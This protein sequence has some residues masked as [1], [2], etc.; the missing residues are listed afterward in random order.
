MWWTAAAFAGEGVLEPGAWFDQ[1]QVLEVGKKGK[2][3]N[4]AGG[5]PEKIKRLAPNLYGS[6]IGTGAV[7]LPLWRDGAGAVWT[8]SALR[9][10]DDIVD[11]YG[12]WWSWVDGSCVPRSE[13][14]EP[15]NCGM[16]G[17]RFLLNDAV[18]QPLAPGVWADAGRRLFRG[19]DAAAARAAAHDGFLDDATRKRFGATGTWW[20][21]D[22]ETSTLRE[23]R[24]DGAVLALDDTRWP[25]RPVAPCFLEVGEEG[26]RSLQAFW[27]DGAH[28]AL[29]RVAFADGPVTWV[30]DGS[31]LLQVTAAACRSWSWWSEDADGPGH[32]LGPYDCA[33]TPDAP[34]SASG[35]IP[36][37]TTPGL[38]T[39]WE[40][41]A[42]EP[43]WARNLRSLEENPPEEPAP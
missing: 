39:S 19:A 33:A 11:Q 20:S 5:E 23:V 38:F 24:W 34:E 25:A 28:A 21:P 18:L 4:W 30:C 27:T 42:E 43:S 8:A 13:L 9:V 12:S 17:E 15:A 35:A 7:L 2:T 16:D 10:G 31:D 32:W 1:G 22:S 36:A 40:L 3:A 41:V 29:D 14:A 37:T 6:P 26:S